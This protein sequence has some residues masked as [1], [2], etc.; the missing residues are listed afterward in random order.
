MYAFK[1]VYWCIR[2]CVW[3]MFLLPSELMDA[4]DSG[5]MRDL[6]WVGVPVGGQC[7]RNMGSISAC[8]DGEAPR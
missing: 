5:C 6:E 8:P 3:V 1:G 7:I 4:W 2:V